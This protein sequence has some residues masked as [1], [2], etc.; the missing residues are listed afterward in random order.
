MDALKGFVHRAIPSQDNQFD[1]QLFP[2]AVIGGG[3]FGHSPGYMPGTFGE[4]DI[5]RNLP[6]FEYLPQTIPN[7]APLAGFRSRVDDYII[8]KNPHF[9]AAFFAWIA[10]CFAAAANLLFVAAFNHQP[11]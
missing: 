6:F 9:R 1:G 7:S 3:Q 5:I 10:L 8:H 2:P 4:E 11:F